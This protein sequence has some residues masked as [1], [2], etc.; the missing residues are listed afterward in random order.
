MTTLNTGHDQVRR[1]GGWSGGDSRRPA[2]GD[3]AERLNHAI[4]TGARLHPAA[5]AAR[6]RTISRV[7]DNW[8]QIPGT[9]FRFGLDPVIGLVPGIGDLIAFLISL[10]IVQLARESGA[11]KRAVAQMM[12]RIGLDFLIGLLP[13]V[14][15]L[16][17]F[18]YKANAKNTEHLER[19]AERHNQP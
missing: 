17:D 12:G 13:L 3:S 5:A 10:Y 9:S 14:G 7:L 16:G 18:V 1:V 15:D 11:P 19:L 6:A 8:I 2:A 4:P